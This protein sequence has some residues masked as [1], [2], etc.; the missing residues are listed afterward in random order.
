MIC[1]EQCSTGF[2]YLLFYCIIKNV[3]QQKPEDLTREEIAG[4]GF[5]MWGATNCVY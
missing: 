5:L 1:Q 3:S 4:C 2:L